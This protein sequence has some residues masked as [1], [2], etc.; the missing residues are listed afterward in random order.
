M[1]RDQSGV[2][3]RRGFETW[4]LSQGV[5][6]PSSA[7]SYFQNSGYRPD[8]TVAFYQLDLPSVVSLKKTLTLLV[9]L[10]ETRAQARS[11]EQSPP[12][13]S[14]RRDGVGTTVWVCL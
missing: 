14:R 13:A 10:Q 9:S 3:Q 11:H 6:L 4:L 1:E 2:L 7:H 12:T 5:A 8:G